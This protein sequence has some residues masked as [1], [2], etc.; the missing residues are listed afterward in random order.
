M[1][2]KYL[3]AE[4][5]IHGGGLDLMF[6]HH[7]CEIAQ[8]QAC[9]QPTNEAQV[10]MHNNMITVN[11]QKMS[12]SLGNFITITDLFEG[13]NVTLPQPYSPM[14]VRFFLLQA[15]YRSTIDITDEALQ[16]LAGHSWPG[17]F[18]ELRSVLTR[19]LLGRASGHQDSHLALRDVARVLPVAAPVNTSALQHNASSVARRAFERSGGSVSQTAWALGVSRTTVYRHLRGGRG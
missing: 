16:Q 17:N 3:G 12:K 6:P 2:R 10:W 7:E 18:R 8:S 5:D 9:N 1:S 14:T 13:R 15:H 19:A 11:G 4:F